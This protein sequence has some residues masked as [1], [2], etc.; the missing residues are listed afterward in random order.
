ME[1]LLQQY[2][3][4]D[5]YIPVVYI[6]PVIESKLKE[7]I[8]P[9]NLYETGAK[10]IGPL[11]KILNSCGFRVTCNMKETGTLI[12]NEIVRNFVA[13]NTGRVIEA[14]VK[15]DYDFEYY[16]QFA[17]PQNMTKGE[18]VI[19]AL[20]SLEKELNVFPR[21]VDALYIENVEHKKLFARKQFEPKPVDNEIYHNWYVQSSNFGAAAG[22]INLP[23]IAGV[24]SAARRARDRYNVKE[25]SLYQLTK[26]EIEQG[27]IPNFLVIGD[28]F[29]IRSL[30]F[31]FDPEFSR[32]VFEQ[33]AN[34]VKEK[35]SGVIGEAVFT[36]CN[37][38]KFLYD[39]ILFEE[40]GYLRYLEQYSEKVGKFNTYDYD[41]N[42]LVPDEYAFALEEDKQGTVFSQFKGRV[43]IAGE[44]HSNVISVTTRQENIA[45]GKFNEFYSLTSKAG[46]KTAKKAVENRGYVTDRLPEGNQTRTVQFTESEVEDIVN[47]VNKSVTSNIAIESAVQ[48]LAGQNATDVIK[49]IQKK[50]V[51]S[52]LQSPNVKSKR[53][54][55][56]GFAAYLDFLQKVSDEARSI[57]IKIK[58]DFRISSV[59]VIS[60]PAFFFHSN[61]YITSSR[62]SVSNLSLL[63]GLYRIV[64]YNHVI[65]SSEAYT[66]VVL[67]RD[68]F[69]DSINFQANN[70]GA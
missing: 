44:Q 13:F 34:K 55:K 30:I 17:P 29:L 32:G 31:P 67:L 42:T 36:Y 25:V 45:F 2:L 38:Y 59:G 63:S 33:Y 68:P 56:E 53:I 24:T 48:A 47:E 4:G 62:S 69:T 57:I 39:P 14:D 6:N 58:P 66:Q 64:G 41:E 16:L 26:E 52:F 51:E 37:A 61:P 40:G 28:D 60:Q 22:N 65:N 1:R 49:T 12:E 46:I 7:K 50:V 70:I 20:R 8:N 35:M 11:T 18:A 27:N 23:A 5:S 21:G 19:E 15:K 54:S 9:Q 3:H 43:Y 10:L